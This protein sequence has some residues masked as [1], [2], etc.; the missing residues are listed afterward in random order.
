MGGIFDLDILYRNKAASN[1]HTRYFHSKC[2]VVQLCYGFS[3]ILSASFGER[4]YGL[5]IYGML[6]LR[7]RN[8]CFLLKMCM[9]QF[10]GDLTLRRRFEPLSTYI[11]VAFPLICY[12][13]FSP[14]FFSFSFLFHPVLYRNSGPYNRN[15]TPHPP[16]RPAPRPLNQ[17]LNVKRAL[18]N[19]LLRKTQ[20]KKRNQPVKSLNQLMKEQLHKPRKEKE[21][22]ERELQWKR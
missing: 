9:H 6:S 14:Y 7:N 20:G 21:R 8:G 16:H 10:R 2:A 19:L 13:N 18:P 17:P 5:H 3:T 15:K 4:S 22:E 11:H 1:K 12:S